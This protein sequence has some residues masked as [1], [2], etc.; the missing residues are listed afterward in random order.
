M[1][2]KLTKIKQASM[3]IFRVPAEGSEGQKPAIE[4]SY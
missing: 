4:Q 3:I 2:S 1:L